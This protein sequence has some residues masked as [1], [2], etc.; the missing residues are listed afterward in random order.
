MIKKRDRFS[1]PGDRFSVKVLCRLDN[2]PPFNW[3]IIGSDMPSV[4]G[5][6]NGGTGLRNKSKKIAQRICPK[7]AMF[8]LKN[9][10]YFHYAEQLLCLNLYPIISSK[11]FKK[12]FQNV[13]F[14]QNSSGSG[15]RD[16]NSIMM[17]P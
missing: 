7:F 12:A 3:S 15:E 1:V 8:L 2:Y 5:L 13:L 11:L 17:P 16:L 10:M 4:L 14:E 9:L 6:V